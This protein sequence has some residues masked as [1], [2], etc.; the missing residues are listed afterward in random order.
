MKTFL[1]AAATLAAI[2]WFSPGDLTSQRE[3]CEMV[4]IYRDTQGQHGWPPY[5][6]TEQCAADSQ[7]DTP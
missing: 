5:K 7:G 6:G 4:G 2:A 1:L 3:Y